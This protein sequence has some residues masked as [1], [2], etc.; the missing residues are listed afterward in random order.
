MLELISGDYPTKNQNAHGLGKH[1]PRDDAAAERAF[2]EGLPH[3]EGSPNAGRP[4]AGAFAL[5]GHMS[6]EGRGVGV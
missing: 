1:A 2:F 4:G 3:P 5:N 6:A